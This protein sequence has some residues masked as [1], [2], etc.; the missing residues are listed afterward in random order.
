MPSTQHIEVL[1]GRVLWQRIKELL[2]FAKYKEHKVATTLIYRHLWQLTYKV[3]MSSNLVKA[4]KFSKFQYSRRALNWSPTRCSIE[5]PWPGLTARARAKTAPRRPRH[6]HGGA[7]CGL[8]R[9]PLRCLP[10]PPPLPRQG[11]TDGPS[12]T[13]TTIITV[14]CLFL[15]N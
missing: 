8:H 10:E 1:K 14:A 5:A 11:E 2:F 13:A 7:A 9:L 4:C 12:M 15:G 3:K 6:G